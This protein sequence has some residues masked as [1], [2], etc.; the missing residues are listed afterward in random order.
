MLWWDAYAHSCALSAQIYIRDHDP[1]VTERV[2]SLLDDHREAL[3]IGRI[4]TVEETRELY[5]SWG[6]YSF[7]VETDGKTGFGYDLSAPL[8][9]P[10]DNSD[11]RCSVASHGHI[12]ES[13]PQP[14]FAVRDP[15]RKKQVTIE[16]GRIIDQ[17]P[18]LARLLDFEMPDCDGRPI[19]ELL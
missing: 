18:T 7:M 9:C 4:F 19:Q 12:P 17:A 6:D 5:H 3:G 2:R 15:F 13:G 1:A 10:V 8:I 14:C 16:Q 11:Y